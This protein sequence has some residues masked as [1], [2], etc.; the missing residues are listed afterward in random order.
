M[1]RMRSRLL[2]KL[3]AA[4]IPVI[5]VVIVIIWLAMDYLAADYFM[6]L[7]KDYNIDPTS[8]HRMFLDS[9]H[10]YMIGACVVSLVLAVL[11]S[12]F[13]CRM[14]LTPLTQ[15]TDTVRRMAAGEFSARV[16]PSSRDE[17]GQLAV[18]FNRMAENLERIEQLRR[19]MVIDV[20]HELRTPLTNIQGY[21]EGLRDG[22][23]D[24]DAETFDLIHEE[25]L[26]LA[27][28]IEDVL[29]LARAE[30]AEITLERQEVSLETLIDEAVDRQQS[31][32]IDKDIGVQTDIAAN[33]GAIKADPEKL[34]RVLVNL[35]Q[36]AW[37]YNQGGGKV[38]LNARRT[39][40]EIVVSVSNTGEVIPPKDLPLIFERFYRGEKSRSRK[41]GGAGI[42][43][44]VVKKLVEAHGGRVGAES[45]ARATRIWFTL[46]VQ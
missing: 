37:Q 22:V 40:N 42:G 25:S 45:D 3:L 5:A 17:V 36:N 21:V 41:H 7:M 2:W 32:L 30:A 14:V 26:R 1:I 38:E 18:A 43:L 23:I 8:T 33:V 34:S 31:H 19:N 13:L 20:A 39:S 15:I 9:I 12:Y 4:N 35:L 46:P 11:A 16:H 24:S 28:L 6:V 29:D 44:A 27:K 10:R